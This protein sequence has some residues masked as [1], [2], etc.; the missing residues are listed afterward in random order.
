MKKLTLFAI[1]LLASVVSFALNPFAYG[2][3]SSLSDDGVTLTVNYSLNA[4]AKAVN[5]VVLNGEEVV[6][7]I[8]CDGIAKGDHS[9]QVSTVELPKS[10]AL[11][12]K[13]NV[14]GTSVEVPTQETQMYN[15][16]CPH[17][18]AIDNDP[19]SEYFA[20]I[21][22]AEAMQ[23]VPASGYISSGKGAGLYVF[24]PDFTTDQKVH[25]GGLNFT[26]IL[27][28]NGYQPYR[29]KIS[30]DGRIFVSSLD[31]NG[32]AVWEVSKDLQTWT[33]V[34]AGTN[35]ATDYNIYDANGNF[36]AGPNCSMDV[37]GKGEDLKLLLY[38]TNNKGIAN[39]QSG[40]RLDEYALGTATTWTGTP[41]NIINGGAYGLVHTN[42]EWI[43]DGEGG[44]WFGASRAGN[45]GQPNLVHINAEGVEDYRSE[46]AS[47]YG[48]DGVLVHN[49]MLF[50]G[51]ARTSGT[52]G[53]FGV[54][55][56]GKGADGK[57]TLTEKW[58]VVANGIGRN[59]NEFAI[60]YAENL[61]VVGNSGEK[62]IAYALPYSGTVST[63][64]AAKYAFELQEIQATVYTITAT[65]NNEAMG[66]V[67]G[68][69]S[70]IEGK[71]VTLT[72]T[73]K[74]GH[75]F[76]DWSNG[77][78]TNPLVFNATEDVE[79]TANFKALQY[80]VTVGV[81]D[82]A[83][84]SV[85]HAGANTLDY[86]TKLVLEATPAEGN[87]FVQWSTGATD[88]PLTITVAKDLE[89]AALFEN[90]NIT[91]RA[92]A[93]DLSLTT[94]GDNYT[95]TFKATTPATA[96][97]IFTNADGEE[98]GLVELGTIA[99]GVNTK[100][101]TAA[102]IPGEGKLNW[103]VKMAYDEVVE[104][105][106]VTDQSRGIYNFYS[107]MDVLVDN[108]PESEYFGKIYIQQSM[109]GE[110]DGATTR[111]QTQKSGIFIYDQELNELNP[112]SNVG[113][114]PTLPAGYAI[115][116]SRNTFHRLDIDPKTG[117]LTYCYNIAGQPAVF[118]MDRANLT[119]EMTNL[120][121]GIDGI[122][123]TSA[124]CFDAEGALYVYD[125]P[126][127]ATIYKIVDG[128]AT[129]FAASDAKW[130]QAS[131]TMAVDGR[132]GLWVAQNRGQMD[133]YYQLAHYTK[134]GVLDYAV[135]EG[136]T[137][138]FTGGSARGALAYD[139]ERHILAQGRNGA[140][141]L[142]N[143]AYDAETGVPT[144]TK[145]A[146][147][148]AIATN[149]DGLH[150]DYAGDLYVVNS[151]TEKFQKFV[152]PTD[153]NTC[154]TPAASKYAFQLEAA[155]VE[156]V[157]L[158]GVV[159]RAL[160]IGESTVVLTHEA[161]GTAHIYNIVGEEIAEVSLEGVVP[162][163]PEN[164]G[165]YLAISDI[166]ATEDGKLIANNYV[167]CQFGTSTAP[168]DG[169]KRGTSYYYIW[170]DLAG[171]PAVWFTS[172]TTARSSHGDIGRTFAVK[173]TSANAQILVTAVHNNNRAVRMS[174]HTIIDGVYEDPNVDG[175][176][177]DSE[178]YMNFGLHTKSNYYKEETQGAEYY[179]LA[180]PLAEK[181]WIIEAE[182]SEPSEF[183]VPNEVGADYTANQEI[184]AGTLGKKYQGT[185]IV[186][187][188][189]Q[190]LMVAPYADAEGKLAGVKVLD[191]TAG[192]ASAT[193]VAVADL[194]AAVEATAAATAVVVDED[195]LIITLV[196]DATLYTLTAELTQDPGPGTALDNIAVE[197]KAIKVIK[198]GQ[199]IIIKNGVQ[200]NAQGAVVK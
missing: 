167:R 98:T 84:G 185:T 175:G 149:I 107:M 40:Y 13:V 186:T 80:T 43:Y 77:E 59:L 53:N 45:A 87:R 187:I 6:A 163:D 68:A 48:G 184:A 81:N 64:A 90:T 86:G 103:A 118:A 132:G 147:T 28:S 15:M 178:Y 138:G 32:V 153:N 174:L 196:G 71:E 115:G 50:K 161:D 91:A 60:D 169:Y 109:N 189:D 25:N 23:G 170:N 49:G 116:T 52:V 96:T 88:N 4:N 38:S 127:A 7:T 110:S 200:Y 99:A 166:A 190:H 105:R 102:E 146:T 188:D 113:I 119:G 18:L 65:P 82:E 16:Y 73:P 192:L 168:G 29:V 55:T 128:V 126:A 83:K 141:E 14:E 122:S 193:E 125:L 130:V 58:S 57:V 111:S 180:S 94:E 76:V 79:L 134:D 177:Y 191:I 154:T 181:S 136:N 139:A 183:L 135:Y 95:F 21:L 92:W 121:A 12:W 34:I 131:A 56:I 11:T 54:W 97:L 74:T 30:E 26:R 173:G 165:S 182:L 20:R 78:T 51:K 62:I 133:I 9:V 1:A 41:K 155:V 124:H 164:K 150:F 67:A 5:V 93:Y 112:T 46:A 120:V 3:S 63:P 39:N 159:K 171:A 151:S 31:L 199:L 42:V 22:V 61:Y 8:P 89:I 104:L 2:L 162:V 142:F 148:P 72:A 17:G 33:P 145:F 143:V 69:G 19:N 75:I 100:T 140:V 152:I 157:E 70:Y 35:N 179:L 24:N 108:N 47:L 66:T 156:P 114:Q 160:T 37:T 137:N 101:L 144:L 195:K 27:A 106:E 194:D 123:R 85:T 10:V 44:F 197:G 198:N 117:N 36:V 129:V 172:Q 176:I 158:V